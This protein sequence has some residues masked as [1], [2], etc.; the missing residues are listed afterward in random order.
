MVPQVLEGDLETNRTNGTA[1]PRT[2]VGPAHHS[3]G[4]AWSFD[5]HKLLLSPPYFKGHAPAEWL[6]R[7]L[8]GHRYNNAPSRRKE[9]LLLLGEQKLL[10]TEGWILG[11]S[12]R[13]SDGVRLL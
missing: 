13:L 6:G 12:R 5:A 1:C 7:P 11:D 4:G 8:P 9:E 2:P 3:L 10:P